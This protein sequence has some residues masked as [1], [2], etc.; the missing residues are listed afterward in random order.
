MRGMHDFRGKLQGRTEDSLIRIGTS[1]AVIGKNS[2]PLLPG[3]I[4]N[5]LK[6]ANRFGKIPAKV[7]HCLINTNGDTPHLAVKKSKVELPP[8]LFD[9]LGGG[10]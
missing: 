6:N 1:C 4:A 2:S 3:K 5:H 8:S 7:I 9:V 10:V